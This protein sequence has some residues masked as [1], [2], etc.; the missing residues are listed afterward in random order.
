MQQRYAS[1]DALILLKIDVLFQETGKTRNAAME[2]LD[3]QFLDTCA[4]SRVTPNRFWNLKIL[5]NLGV[6]RLLRIFICMK[7]LC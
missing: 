7:S 6:F 2:R 3:M 5:E 1:A 4:V